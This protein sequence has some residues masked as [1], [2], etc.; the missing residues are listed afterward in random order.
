MVGDDSAGQVR[1]VFALQ[2]NTNVGSD[3]RGDEVEQALDEVG[4]DGEALEF[5]G[6]AGVEYHLLGL[7]A[8][9][10]EERA[11]VAVETYEAAGES[12]CDGF[13]G[14][15][16]GEAEW[17]GHFMGLFLER[18][19]IGMNEA[20]RDGVFLYTLLLLRFICG[21]VGI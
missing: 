14:S 8:G 21:V 9:R 3:M 20:C 16:G 10:F 7:E 12:V 11:V 15:E 13:A 2:L 1:R 17:S 5:D 6:G 19:D 18:C 4:D